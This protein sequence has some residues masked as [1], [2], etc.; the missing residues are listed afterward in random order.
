M[1]VLTA[2]FWT[3]WVDGE[4]YRGAVVVQGDAVPLT[5]LSKSGP[6]S[7]GESCFLR[8]ISGASVWMMRLGGG[9]T[10]RFLDYLGM[11]LCLDN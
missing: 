2:A 3:R 6:V 5:K 10:D 4:A 9:V 7:P 11:N 1:N 8:F